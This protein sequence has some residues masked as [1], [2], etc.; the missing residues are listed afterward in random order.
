MIYNITLFENRG[1]FEIK[2]TKNIF[3]YKTGIFRRKIETKKEKPPSKGFFFFF[4]KHS[5]ATM[6]RFH[7]NGG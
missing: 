3:M 1:F 6:K 5:I 2:M 7:K 4:T